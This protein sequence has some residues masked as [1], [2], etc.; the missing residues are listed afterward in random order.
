MKR[1]RSDFESKSNGEPNLPF[2][3]TAS[4]SG[5]FDQV[6]IVNQTVTGESVV[7]NQTVALQAV[8]DQNVA[9]QQ[10][11]SQVIVN[12]EVTGEQEVLGTS[13]FVGEVTMNDVTAVNILTDTVAATDMSVS[14]IATISHLRGDPDIRIDLDTGAGVGNIFVEG[15][16]SCYLPRVRCAILSGSIEETGAGGP[17]SIIAETQI[18]M[19]CPTISI[20]TTLNVNNLVVSGTTQ[21][22]PDGSISDVFTSA[23]T[24]T[25]ITANGESAAGLTNNLGSIRVGSG[26][27]QL[28]NGDSAT[29]VFTANGGSIGMTGETTVT[30]SFTASTQSV[31]ESFRTTGSGGDSY[32]GCSGDDVSFTTS[33]VNPVTGYQTGQPFIRMRGN[34]SNPSLAQIEVWDGTQALGNPFVRAQ[35][36]VLTI[37]GQVR[38]PLVFSTTSDRVLLS[39]NGNNNTSIVGAAMIEIDSTLNQINIWDGSGIIN[40]PAVSIRNGVIYSVQ[41]VYG[42]LQD[43]GYGG[44]QSS[45]NFLWDLSGLGDG[46]AY[47]SLGITPY[48]SVNSAACEGFEIT[49]PGLYKLSAGSVMQGVSDYIQ[50]TVNGT[51]FC[52]TAPTSSGLYVA[53]SFAFMAASGDIVR[54][55]SSGSAALQNHWLHVEKVPGAVNAFL[56][57][58]GSVGSYTYV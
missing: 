49:Q 6:T 53:A 57:T 11:A 56:A 22:I 27:V 25:A 55:K 44:A 24:S 10:V 19:S 1:K 4:T 16:G 40:G 50:I 41:P 37:D 26:G 23:T 39:T 42:Y 18:T 28:Y 51:E 21:G 43:G 45:P 38:T 14:G 47:Y 36:G 34:N 46:R 7:E 52:R 54:A 17:L 48:P 30:G 2:L 31:A 9:T 32:Y 13:S 33:N 20:P 12:Q 58:V 29:P 8:V 5:N 3:S 35:A 15:G